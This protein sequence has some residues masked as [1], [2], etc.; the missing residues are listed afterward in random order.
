[1]YRRLEGV[2]LG[3]IHSLWYATESKY[4][5]GVSDLQDGTL[6]EQDSQPR[7]SGDLVI[8]FP[9]SPLT[10]CLRLGNVEDFVLDENQ[11]WVQH[12]SEWEFTDE[13]G[14]RDKSING[15][16]PGFADHVKKQVT[17]R[18]WSL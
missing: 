16:K 1:M 8:P 11:H 10:V 15:G 3:I 2:Q 12:S 17:G 9:E 13:V 4:L 5:S 7:R 6:L 18:W 14:L